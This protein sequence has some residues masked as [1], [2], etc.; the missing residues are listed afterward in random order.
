MEVEN[1]SFAQ[2]SSMSVRDQEQ[3]IHFNSELEGNEEDEEELPQVLSDDDPSVESEGSH[4]MKDS[5]YRIIDKSNPLVY[6][7]GSGSGNSGI[8]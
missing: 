2:V 3:H 6:E 4:Y 7:K 1:P 5:Y 8:L